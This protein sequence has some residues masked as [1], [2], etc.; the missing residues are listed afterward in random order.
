VGRATHTWNVFGEAVSKILCYLGPYL[1][2]IWFLTTVL[3]PHSLAR[4]AALPPRLSKDLYNPRH[5]WALLL[6]ILLSWI[7]LIEAALVFH[8]SSPCAIR[9]IPWRGLHS[10]FN[11][12][13]RLLALG[14]V[15]WGPYAIR[16]M[17]REPG[18]EGQTPSARSDR[19][20]CAGFCGH[21]VP[22]VSFPSTAANWPEVIGAIGQETGPAFVVSAILVVLSCR[23]GRKYGCLEV[24][25]DQ[26]LPAH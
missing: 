1:A 13:G 22:L 24:K 19:S 3:R 25:D 5:D 8:E 10:A 6:V 12:A 18:R 26:A 7:V 20:G 17:W 11:H 16:R 2:I 14:A 23:A 21:I 4:A 9:G 15:V